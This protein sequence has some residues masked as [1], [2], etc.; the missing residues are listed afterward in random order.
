MRLSGW[1]DVFDTLCTVLYKNA[2]IFFKI[3]SSSDTFF[4]FNLISKSLA[5]K[6]AEQ[7]QCFVCLDLLCGCALLS[8]LKKQPQRV[9][10]DCFSLCCFSQLGLLS[11]LSP[12]KVLHH[13][14]EEA[15]SEQKPTFSL[16]FYF[17]FFLP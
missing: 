4:K 17:I 8:D 7:E 15:V 11:L 2:L 3:L 9:K 6:Y 10:R 1:K 14:S 16:S 12:T 5:G 13:I